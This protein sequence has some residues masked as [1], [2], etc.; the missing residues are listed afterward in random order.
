MKL[1]KICRSP[2]CGGRSN[3]EGGG[4][5]KECLQNGSRDHCTK[6]NVVFWN[7]SIERK[8]INRLMRQPQTSHIFFFSYFSFFKRDIILHLLYDNTTAKLF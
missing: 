5:Q 2:N 7:F 1:G 4:G 8:S 6:L 3:V